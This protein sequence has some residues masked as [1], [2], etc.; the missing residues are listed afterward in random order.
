MRIGHKNSGP[1]VHPVRLQQVY[2]R[3]RG[4]R[5]RGPRSG[6]WRE[7]RVGLVDGQNGPSKEANQAFRPYRLLVDY[8][9]G[10]KRLYL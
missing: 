5:Y 4:G 2:H 7:P 1:P 6:G 8:L 10:Q 3:S 9:K